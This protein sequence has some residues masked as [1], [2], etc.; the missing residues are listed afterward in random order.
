[1]GVAP[2]AKWAH[3]ESLAWDEL[4][5]DQPS[6]AFVDDAP[7]LRAL[8]EAGAITVPRI[9]L[10][11]T[12]RGVEAAA[13]IRAP[14]PPLPVAFDVFVR[15]AGR[16]SKLWPPF[17]SDVPIRIRPGDGGH[18]GLIEGY[19]GERTADVVFRP[20]PKAAAAFSPDI[21]RIWNGEL[22]LRNV[23]VIANAVVV[24]ERRGGW[25]LTRPDA[26]TRAAAT[27]D[28]RR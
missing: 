7:D 1:M 13:E 5:A 9:W 15:V 27:R 28:V 11:P 17:V 25:W 12:G 21:D 18:A 22:V 26:A 20:N 23:P 8:M 24:E 10:R 19:G 14:M 6:V 16:E 4:P 2:T 3:V